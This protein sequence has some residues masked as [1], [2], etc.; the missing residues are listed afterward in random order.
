MINLSIWLY[1]KP[2][3]DMDLGDKIDPNIF[4]EQGNYLK[5]HLHN[6]ANIVKKLNST[7]WNCYGTLYT[8]EFSNENIKTKKEAK[9]ELKKLG[10]T[11]NVGLIEIDDEEIEE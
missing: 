1:G 5:E 8:L 2:E 4:I 10:I 7:G 11:D 9:Q 6:V 3:W